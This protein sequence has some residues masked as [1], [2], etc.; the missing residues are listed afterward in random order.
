MHA[1][2]VA[3]AALLIASLTAC[4]SSND[5]KSAAA[6][7][8]AEPA[9]TETGISKECADAVFDL[10][11]D[12]V[13]GADTPDS[14]P[15]ACVDLTDEQWSQ[16]VDEAGDKVLAAGE[17]TGSDAD[18]EAPT[19]AEFKVGEEARNRGTVV[20]IKKVR[21]ANSITF[22]GA[23]KQAGADAKYVILE[24]VVRNETKASMDLTCSLPIVNALIDDQDRRFDTIEDLDYVP[25]NPE[26]NAQLQ[27][28]FKDEMKFVYRVPKDANIVLW[29]FEEYDLETDPAPSLVDLT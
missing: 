24:S 16:A 27:P 13:N 4:G 11:I 28:G 23:A 12:Q 6:P 2:T 17:A 14:R 18:T 7:S 9:A 21:E 3:T 26:C 8:T 20:T 15:D 25:G 29:E 19:E 5:S 22:N 10:M 1:R